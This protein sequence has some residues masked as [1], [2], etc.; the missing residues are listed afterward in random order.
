MIYITRSCN[1][2]AKRVIEDHLCLYG[3]ERFSLIIDN[4]QGVT[5][6]NF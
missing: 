1:E 6:V 5:Y 2:A 3:L 4:V